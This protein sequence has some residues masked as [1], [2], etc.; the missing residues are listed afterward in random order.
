M[1]PRDRVRCKS[2]SAVVMLIACAALASTACAAWVIEYPVQ[3]QK[4]S[5]YVTYVSYWGKD[6]A[7]NV[8]FTVEIRDPEDNTEDIDSGV[9]GSVYPFSFSGRLWRPPAGWH[10]LGTGWMIRLF[11]GGAEQ[12]NVEIEIDY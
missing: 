1:I 3:G 10:P 4:F 5:P 6:T 2:V 8:Q 9:T 12:T 11:S 7:A